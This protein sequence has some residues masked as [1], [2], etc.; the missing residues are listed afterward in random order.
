MTDAELHR[1]PIIAYLGLGS[2]LGDRQANLESALEQ[3]SEKV[4]IV[5]ISS[6]YETDP[7]GYEEQPRFLNA[8]LSAETELPPVELLR[9]IKDVECE[10]GREYS[11]PNA[12]RVIDIDI[13][14][15]GDRVIDSPELTVPHPRLSER[16]F[17]LVPLVEISPRTRHPLNGKTSA[18]MLAKVGGL[19]GVR[20]AGALRVGQEGH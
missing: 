1:D 4:S 18:D 16:A 11:F 10:L 19:E 15:Y 9:F 7:V 2:N 12:P 6:V 8:V 17:V 5:S 20:L 14:L 13:L 3:L